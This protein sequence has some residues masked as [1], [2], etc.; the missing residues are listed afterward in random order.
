MLGS[1]FCKTDFEQSVFRLI[2]A[3]F[4]LFG[5]PILVYSAQQKGESRG[6]KEQLCRLVYFKLLLSFLLLVNGIL[7]AAAT[8]SMHE[9]STLFHL[10]FVAHLTVASALTV[11]CFKKGV[12]SSGVLFF[13]FTLLALSSFSEFRY[14]I[15]RY[16]VHGNVDGF[17]FY[18]TVPFFPMAFVQMI[19]YGFSDYNWSLLDDKKQ[20][21]EPK[22][23][24]LSQLTMSWFTPMV[25]KG[26]R[27]PLEMDDVWNLLDVHRSSALVARF[28]K[29]WNAR[30]ASSERPESDSE[31]LIGREKPKE[32]SVI[33]S[34]YR[35]F[36][37]DLVVIFVLSIVHS[38]AVFLQ[39]FF[40]GKIVTFMGDEAEPAWMGLLWTVGLIVSEIGILLF[41]RQYIYRINFFSV[42][43]NSTLISTIY[44]KALRMSNEARRNRTSGEIVNLMSVDVDV[45]MS[46]TRDMVTLWSA[47]ISLIVATIMLYNLLGVAAFVGIA[48]LCVDIIPYTVFYSFKKKKYDGARM[49]VRDE[50]VKMTNEVLGGIK[51]VKMHAWEESAKKMVNGLRDNEVG[52]LKKAAFLLAGLNISYAYIPFVVV[53]ATLAVF[54]LLDPEHNVVTPHVAFVTISIVRSVVSPVMELAFVLG[55][56]VKFLVSNKRVKSFLNED[57]L[58]DYVDKESK[59]EGII[60]L[61]NASFYWEKGARMTLRDV[62]MAVRSGELVAVVGEVGCGKSS[63]VAALLG[64]MT[65][66]SGSVA[67]AGSVAYVPQQAWIQNATLRNNV[68]FGR[69]FDERFYDSVLEACALKPDLEMLQAGDATEIGERGINLS[70]G[71]KQ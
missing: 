13:Y 70:G 8:S 63:L 56:F 65:K 64:E 46:F 67:V 48:A 26:Y 32:K 2:P 29:Y 66:E 58:E 20:S 62:T 51:A 19:F 27:Q 28:S 43:V 11:L 30:G 4:L 1:V 53:G 14:R 60:S 25:A 33:L 21:P 54:V 71:Q 68:L 44:S 36:W 37:T 16:F 41:Y 9:V 17:L 15:E 59:E 7:L 18:I 40:I 24:I 47:P 49:K 57:E 42:N 45:F 55:T 35:A 23:S 34:L 61:K 39:P 6:T 10:V 12:F 22:S 38:V 69:P 52:L 3:V 31:P 50:R 5:T